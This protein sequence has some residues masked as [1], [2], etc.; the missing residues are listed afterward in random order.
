MR[1]QRSK[2]ECPQIEFIYVCERAVFAFY[3]INNKEKNSQRDLGTP[4][5][6]S[7][8]KPGRAEKMFLQ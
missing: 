1:P 5:A 7:E 2:L 8:H 6:C 4:G 3:F